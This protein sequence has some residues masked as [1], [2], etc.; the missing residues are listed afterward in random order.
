MVRER[1]TAVLAAVRHLTTADDR[2]RFARTRADLLAARVEAGAARPLDRDLAEV[3]WRRS[4]ADVIAWQAAAD[5]AMAAL[6]AS[7]GLS[8]EVPLRLAA[9]LADVALGLPPS[10]QGDAMS[11]RPD[12][13]AKDLEVG[14]ADAE[15]RRVMS[16]SRFDLGLYAAYMTRRPDLAPGRRMHEAAI[17]ATVSLPWRN[18]QQGA[19]ASAGAMKRAAESGAAAHHLDARAEIDAARIREAAAAETLALYRG[20]LMDLAA[21]NL[22]VVREAFDLGRGT[23]LDVIE[24]ERRYLELESAYTAALR[25]VVDARTAVLRVLGVAS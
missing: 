23:L 1:A 21:R 18:R 14:L 22:A 7:V 9:P 25:E 24:E 12:V 16:E 11:A 5:Q 20:G 10:P 19:I 2:A 4:Q 8:G 13:Q 15:V 3:E 6:K 17:G